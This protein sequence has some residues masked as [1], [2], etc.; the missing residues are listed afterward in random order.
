MNITAAVGLLRAGLVKALLGK[1]SED[2]MGLVVDTVSGLLLLDTLAP[3]FDVELT[4]IYS[5]TVETVCATALQQQQH[6]KVVVDFL[7]EDVESK[8]ESGEASVATSL[9]AK[10]RSA[11]ECVIRL[12]LIVSRRGP[13][14]CSTSRNLP[15]SR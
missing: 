4:G 6:S 1:L 9:P 5:D 15:L 10:M 2:E 12:Q 8:N 14:T 13:D 3:D 11:L 7:T